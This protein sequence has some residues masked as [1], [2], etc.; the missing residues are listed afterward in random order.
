MS[1]HTFCVKVLKYSQISFVPHLY[2]HVLCNCSTFSVAN[3]DII[4]QY[5]K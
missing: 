1:L 2:I 5:K 4:L 3:T